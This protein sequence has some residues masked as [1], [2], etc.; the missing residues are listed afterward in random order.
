MKY[1]R[2][3]NMYMKLNFTLFIKTILIR[4]DID[5]IYMKLFKIIIIPFRILAVMNE[6]RFHEETC[7][8]S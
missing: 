8:N 1:L 4:E 7:L 5:E 6:L 3:R 2:K